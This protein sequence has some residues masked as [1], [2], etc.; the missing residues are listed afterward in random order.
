M[1][2]GIK[3]I[4][5]REARDNFIGELKKQKRATATILAYGKDVDQLIEYATSL[6]K[7]DPSVISTQD[8]ENF[9]VHLK[10]QKY[11][12][13]LLPRLFRNRRRLWCWRYR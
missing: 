9:K 7:F 5:L 3:K 13:P 6:H 11:I 12:S 2:E 8:I 1:A 10:N 4:T